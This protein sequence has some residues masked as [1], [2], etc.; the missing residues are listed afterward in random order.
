MTRYNPEMLTVAISIHASR[1]GG[2]ASG[3]A[4]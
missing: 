2:D 4:Y 3:D 1:V